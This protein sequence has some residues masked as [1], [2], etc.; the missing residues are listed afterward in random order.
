M[1]ENAAAVRKKNCGSKSGRARIFIADWARPNGRSTQRPLGCH[2]LK[3]SGRWGVILSEASGRWLQVTDGFPNFVYPPA[4]GLQRSPDFSNPSKSR[5]WRPPETQKCSRETVLERAKKHGY[6]DDSLSLMGNVLWGSGIGD[7]TYVPE[8][9]LSVDPNLSIE[10]ARNESEMVI[11]GAIDELLAKTKVECGEI[12]ILIVNCTVFNPIPSLS[13]NIVNHYKLRE[14]VCCYNL[15]GMGCSASLLAAGLAKRLLQ[16][17]QQ[18]T[19]ALV[20]ST[21]NTTSSVYTGADPSKILL[22]GVF[23]VGGTA[24]LFSNKPSHR[25]HSNYEL[26]HAI[27]TYTASSD[28]TYKCVYMEEDSD[29]ITGITTTK[30][31]L[32]AA[33]SAIEQHLKTLGFL[34]L[35]LSKQLLFAKNQIIRRLKIWKMD[36]YIPKFNRYVEHF[37]PHVGAK[38][39]QDAVQKKL[40]FCADD[41]EASRMTLHRFGNTSS[42]SIWYELAYVEA[43][44]RVKKG[45]WVWQIAYGSGFKCSSLILRALRDVEADEMNPWMC[46]I[47]EYP[48]D[49][50]SVAS[51]SYLFEPS[52]L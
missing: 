13:S 44:G 39:V 33:T 45:D 27:H 24:V 4:A 1:P 8:N 21:E 43:K 47:D 2:R 40:G 10:A 41:M 15:T 34:I 35:P 22:N 52:K 51:F 12:G 17:H 19:C 50:D 37:L 46:D 9:I 25:R 38:P 23:R 20:V 29:G 31:L 36:P 18:N 6:S 42:S 48:V 49:L 32:I 5:V 7:A 3:P 26:L 28:V 30:N 14:D 11:F 16:V